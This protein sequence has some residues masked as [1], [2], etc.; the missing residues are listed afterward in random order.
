MLLSLKPVLF[1]CQFV[2]VQNSFLPKTEKA[3]QL[4][5]GSGKNEVTQWANSCKN[6]TLKPSFSISTYD[7]YSKKN[8]TV[9][10]Q[11]YNLSPTY[12]VGKSFPT[13]YHIDE[14]Q[15]SAASTR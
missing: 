5:K 6:R 3:G 11:R 1:N 9:T 14:C 15:D 4:P 2:Q 12:W 7:G 10:C 8:E 13:N